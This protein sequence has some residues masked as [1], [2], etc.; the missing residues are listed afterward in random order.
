MKA[1]LQVRPGALLITGGD[2]LLAC[3][4]RMGVDR[5]EPLGQIFPGV[6]LAEI[7]ADGAKRQVIAKSGGFGAETLLCDLRRL[8]GQ[9]GRRR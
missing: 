4:R 3:M 8:I 1:L 7:E 9:E 2:T 5:M 6:V